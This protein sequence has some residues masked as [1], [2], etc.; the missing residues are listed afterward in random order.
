[1]K[2]CNGSIL[3]GPSIGDRLQ[4]VPSF[5]SERVSPPQPCTVISVNESHGHYTV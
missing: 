5:G 2:L 4:K 3:H 1:M